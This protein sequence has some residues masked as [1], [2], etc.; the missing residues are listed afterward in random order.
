MTSYRQMI[1]LPFFLVLL[2]VYFVFHGYSQNK[3]SLTGSESVA[4]T[5]E[6]L[7]VAGILYVVCFLLFG[8]WQKASLFAF[9]L[10][11]FQLF[12]GPLLDGLKSISPGFLLAKYSV[13]LPLAFCAFV[14]FFL[15]L[16]RSTGSFTRVI[17]YLNLLLVVLIILDL[18][19]VFTTK[20]AGSH[21]TMMPVC[22]QCEKPDVFIIIADEYPDSTSL[23]TAFQ[24]NNGEF[25]KA[26]RQRG[27][28]VVPR[29]RASY[30]FTPY[31]VASLFG[32]D[33][34][35]HLK[36]RKTA[37]EDLNLCY[38]RIN[39][40]PVLRFFQ[41][42]GYEI[43]NCSIFNVANQPTKARQHYILIGKDRLLSQTF[44]ERVRKDLGYHLVTTLKLQSAINSY[45]YYTK[46]CNETLL[47]SLQTELERK[48]TKPRLVYTHLLMPHFPYY[49]DNAGKLR[50]PSFVTDE[51]NYNKAA[52][53]EYLQYSNSVFLKLIDSVLVKSTKPP[54]V[55]FMGD[56]GFR[57]FERNM[58]AGDPNYYMNLNT[59]F[60]PNRN[61]G[62]FYDSLSGVN[63]FRVLLNASFGQQLPLL[64]DTSFFIHE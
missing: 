10:L 26:L 28:H 55:F 38:A 51:S 5:G 12:F 32:M 44:S 7:L 48:T 15:F 1:S 23:A 24:F 37:T 6:Y 40:N 61:Y 49:Y 53:V 22:Q 14:A 47:A 45:A 2:P 25:L 13:L 57:W 31:A 3:A 41:N 43:R 60:L 63:Q 16:K 59:V 27:F 46:R 50:P 36:G 4:L 34:L 18:P 19:A 39:D 35:P 42:N 64:K 11:F 33:Y 30:N 17:S 9:A 52:F 29:S 58:K 62:P 56:H 8:R 21:Q 20:T 54:I